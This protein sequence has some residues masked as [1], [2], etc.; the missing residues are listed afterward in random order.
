MSNE[1]IPITKY[2]IIQLNSDQ[3]SKHE[4]L[5]IFATVL[6]KLHDVRIEWG[7][8]NEEDVIKVIYKDKKAYQQAYSRNLPIIEKI[9][10]IVNQGSLNP[11][12][13][14][15]RIKNEQFL[16][17]NNQDLF[18]ILKIQSNWLEPIRKNF[19]FAFKFGEIIGIH[20]QYEEIADGFLVFY[21]TLE[22]FKDMQVDKLNY[23][24]LKQWLESKGKWNLKI[25]KILNNIL[26]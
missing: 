26:S 14:N 20:S 8:I 2:S 15:I 23:N 10:D 6:T 9:M 22:D 1:I 7:K 25:E 17:S 18:L 24:E 5:N 12:D 11:N 16:K 19:E 4:I 3:Y 13:I 21:E